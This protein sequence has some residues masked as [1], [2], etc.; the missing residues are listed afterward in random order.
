V[1]SYFG[2]ILF[3]NAILS[4]CIAA[5]AFY[6][7]IP[8]AV[9]MAMPI[10]DFLSVLWRG[11][12]L[13]LIGGIWIHF[14]VYILGGRNGIRQTMKVFMYGM[15]PS[16]LLGWI[17]VIGGVFVIWWIVLDILGLRELAGLSTG[18]AALVMII[19]ILPVILFVFFVL[20]PAVPYSHSNIR[21]ILAV[22]YF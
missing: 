21:N 17:P 13:T 1:F 2:V 20:L 14:W 9:G 5:L 19:G 12:F 10:L 4:A 7:A 8:S 6:S 16:L 3:F 15:T 22:P 11:I 18:K